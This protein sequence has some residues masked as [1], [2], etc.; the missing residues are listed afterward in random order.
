[1]H[2]QTYDVILL[3]GYYGITASNFAGLHG[4][5]PREPFDKS[6]GPT[7]PVQMRG[8]FIKSLH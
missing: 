2:L 7:S 3:C 5:D 8:I 6:W 1:M 4:E